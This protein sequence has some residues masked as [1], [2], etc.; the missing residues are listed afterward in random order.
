MQQRNVCTPILWVE[1]R[2]GFS[3]ISGVD[4][5]RVKEKLSK[6]PPGGHQHFSKLP[7]KDLAVSENRW[8]CANT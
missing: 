2:F 5:N 8:F 1:Q 4:D 3:Q 6:D 7:T